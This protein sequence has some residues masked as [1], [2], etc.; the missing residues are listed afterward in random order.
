ME[1][2]ADSLPPFARGG[3]G[4]RVKMFAEHRSQRVGSRSRCPAPESVVGLGPEPYDLW[5]VNCRRRS[6][7]VNF[8]KDLP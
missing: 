6:E 3:W 5:N 7:I 1:R 2:G 4:G 8:L